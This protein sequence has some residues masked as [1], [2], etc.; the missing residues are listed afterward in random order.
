[1]FNIWYPSSILSVEPV[2]SQISQILLQFPEGKSLH[3][4]DW[5]GVL[6][7]KKKVCLL[8][9]LKHLCLYSF[10]SITISPSCYRRWLAVWWWPAQTRRTSPGPRCWARCLVTGPSAGTWSPWTARPWWSGTS[11]SRATSRRHSSW[12]AAAP[13]RDHSVWPSLMRTGA[14]SPW[15]STR[16]GR[17]SSVCP[18]TW[19]SG[20]SPGCLS[21]HTAS[22]PALLTS[23]YPG[24]STSPRP[25]GASGSHHRSG[26][27]ALF[28][29]LSANKT[30][31]C[32]LCI[33][34]LCTLQ[35]KY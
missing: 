5:I 12:W 2:K 22:S 33:Y 3:D 6:S 27:K 8:F 4:V 7:R 19:S 15:V 30:K 32:V 9:N 24:A 17:W 1:M 23:P 25:H 35:C 11:C 16:T 20:A 28:A 31:A 10:I 29:A 18:G 34:V 21:G 26:Y 13:G 14:R